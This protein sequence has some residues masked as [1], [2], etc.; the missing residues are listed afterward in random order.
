VRGRWGQTDFFEYIEAFHGRSRRH[1]PLGERSS[2]RFLEDWISKH[3]DQP[4]KAAEDRPA[5]KR[6]SMR[7]AFFTATRTARAK[8]FPSEIRHA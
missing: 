2:V 3:V 5:G 4:S 8:A 7:P 1:S 6:N